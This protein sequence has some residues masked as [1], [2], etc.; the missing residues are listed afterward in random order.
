MNRNVQAAVAAAST[1]PHLVQIS[2]MLR[3]F[4]HMFV[5]SAQSLLLSAHPSFFALGADIAVAIS[6]TGTL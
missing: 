3:V 4:G 1:F 5:C 6:V 2:V